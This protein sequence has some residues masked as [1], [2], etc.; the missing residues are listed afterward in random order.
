MF[1]TLGWVGA[2]LLSAGALAFEAKYR[3]R[4]GNELEMTNGDWRLEVSEPQHYR[5][6]GEVEL[7]NRTDAL[8]IMVPEISVEP[9]LL[10][11]ASLDGVSW[12][13]KI[14]P[15]HPDEKA[16]PDDY[17]FAY[18]VKIG[19]R[20]R[21]RV[22]VDITGPG[23]SNL[24]VAWLKLHYMTYGPEG[25]IPKTHHVIVPLSFPET[26][27]DPAWRNKDGAELL[28][29]RT[30]LLT[31][32][33]NPVE[34]VKRYVLPY[35]Q[36]GDVVTIGE[37]PIAIMQN[38]MRHPSTVKPGWVAQ[39]VCYFFL[40]TSSLATA[41]GLQTLVDYEGAWRVF[42]AFL[43]G[44]VARVFG[45]RGGFYELAGEQARLIDDVTGTLPP[46]DQFIVL[47]PDD[48]QGVVDEIKR[49]TG[50]ACAI[51]DVNDLRRV[52]V[53][54]STAG[55]SEDFLNNALRSNPAGNADEQTPVVLLRPSVG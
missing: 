52:K 6:V 44:A 54:A 47:G 31:P 26:E 5:V 48:P 37:T 17:W 2:G 39:R 10:S 25:R 40:P 35:A 12:T 51:V 24:Q 9:K 4:Q 42:G 28:P 33:D 20:T 41:C 53:L 11:K 30:H 23:L 55:V 32:L 36:A 22:V 46:Y 14:T 8:E 29:V 21:L 13:T 16:R 3:G 19:K 15:E 45:R 34:V 1:G 27:A 18:I 7:V 38:R 43:G 50:L 49:E